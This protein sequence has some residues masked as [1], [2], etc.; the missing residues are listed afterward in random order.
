MSDEEL[1]AVINRMQMERTYASLTAPQK[2][3]G[4]KV[5]EDILSKALMNTVQKYTTQ[6][7]DNAVQAMLKKA[8]KA[9]SS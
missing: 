1:R 8:K 4:Q 3:K 5:V 2:A 9:G 7:I 6:A